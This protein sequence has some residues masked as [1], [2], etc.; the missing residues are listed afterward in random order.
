[1][2]RTD[3]ED[4]ED[5]SP[6]NKER[7]NRILDAAGKLIVHYGFDKT[8]VDDIAREAGISKGAIYLHWSSK[9]KLFEALIWHEAW[10]YL[11]DILAAVD[12]DPQGGTLTALLKHSILCI[13][14]RPLMRALY[15][16]DRRIMGDFLKRRDPT[17]GAKR[18]LL[19]KEYIQAMQ[20]IGLVRADILPDVLAFIFSCFSAGL[21]A[22]GDSVGDEPA[23][24][25]ESVFEGLTAILGPALTP[26]GVEDTEAG[27]RLL[28]S[29]VDH[30]I[31]MSPNIP[32][33]D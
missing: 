6:Q 31:A 20:Q 25:F 10:A 33:P 32:K 26:E 4:N 19:N 12:A 14:R 29:V 3:N 24:P 11:K 2:A 7:A 28:H 5:K 18:Y 22:L 16:R 13:T 21:L 27:K 30:Y 23:P 17:L 9:D 8:T 15:N 1:M